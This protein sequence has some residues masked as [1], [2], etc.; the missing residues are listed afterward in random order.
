MLFVLRNLLGQKTSEGVVY[1]L[2]ASK[3]ETLQVKRLE[4][5]VIRYGYVPHGR[6]RD[7]KSL[8]EVRDE[9]SG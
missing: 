9:A 7:G 5:R 8:R 2:V 4:I 6:E 1:Y 3:V